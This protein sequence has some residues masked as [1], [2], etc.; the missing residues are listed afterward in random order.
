MRLGAGAAQMLGEKALKSQRRALTY[1]RMIIVRS[2]AARSGDPRSH[3]RGD[4]Q[5]ADIALD[6]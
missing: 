3:G 1:A 2:G 6:S 4:D 5:S